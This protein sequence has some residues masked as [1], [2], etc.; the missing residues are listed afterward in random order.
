MRIAH[1]LLAL[2]LVAIGSAPASATDLTKIDRTIAKEPAYKSK[3]QYCLLVFGLQARFRVWLVRDGDVLYVDRNGNGDLTEAGEQVKRHAH[4]T[5][6][7]RAGDITQADEKLTHRDLSV[8]FEETWGAVKVTPAGLR[9]QQTPRFASGYWDTDDP[10]RFADKPHRAPI[11]HF[12]G[13]LTMRLENLSV[14]ERGNKPSELRVRIG[15]PGLGKGTFAHFGPSY[16]TTWMKKKVL[17][18]IEFP[19][20]KGGP[21]QIAMELLFDG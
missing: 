10:L 12:A 11:I 1:L 3:P 14:L 15:T 18:T 20:K 17:A 5:I 7:F 16:L 9:E 8:M 13:P 6:F 4:P 19:A 21:K 2:P